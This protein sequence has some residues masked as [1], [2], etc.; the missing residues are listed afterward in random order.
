MNL[1]ALLVAYPDGSLHSA[2]G[3][4]VTVRKFT[5]EDT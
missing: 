3:E 2:D 4:K 5:G 1:D